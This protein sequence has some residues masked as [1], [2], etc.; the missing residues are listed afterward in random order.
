MS[1]FHSVILF[2]GRLPCVSGI[3]FLHVTRLSRTL[4][5][6]LTYSDLPCSY[7]PYIKCLN[8]S[9]MPK[10]GSASTMEEHIDRFEYPADVLSLWQEHRATLPPAVTLKCLIKA[11]HLIRIQKDY[12]MLSLPTFKLLL[13]S[14]LSNTS[15]LDAEDLVTL[16]WLM[17]KLKWVN[18]T[19]L[20]SLSK[21]LGSKVSELSDKSLGL[22]PWSL[23][24][25]KVTDNHRSLMKLVLNQASH[26]LEQGLLKDSRALANI[27]WSLSTSKTWPDSFTSLVNQFLK[28]E[29]DKMSSHTLS[30]FLHSLSKAGALK[31]ERW[32]FDTV[33]N[34][35]SSFKSIDSQSLILIL[36]SIGN[37]KKYDRKFFESL[38]EEILSENLVG[39]YN[40]RVLATLLWCCAKV[41]YYNRD[42]LDHLSEQIPNF[43]DQMTLQD[44]S[45]VG[46]SFGY[47]NYP[48]PGLI[49]TIVNRVMTHHAWK[50]NV[51][52][53]AL[54]NLSWAC[55][56]N[57]VYPRDLLDLCL[58]EKIIKCKLSG[59]GHCTMAMN[60]V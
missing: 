21:A 44:L 32:L 38:T 22:V 34:S 50:P 36:W 45:M 10:N 14:S 8:F 35:V 58:S 43:V 37:A 29:G 1:F 16:L 54:L 25:L 46:Y 27:C 53:Q 39:K 4:H 5:L 17:A 28:A 19:I 2:S 15:D 20:N 33:S 51:P 31:S 56:I 12:S 18:H 7:L 49:R 42:L 55:L 40:P 23:V 6:H 24:N 52:F 30:L 57:E 3:R 59:W 9:A 13:R 47:L 48:C 60:I 41:Q 26:R 11:I